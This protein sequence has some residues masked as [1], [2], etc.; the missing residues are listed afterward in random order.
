MKSRIAV[1]G[2]NK[3]VSELV[4]GT[5]WFNL[6]QKEASF[7][8]MDAFVLQGGTAIDTARIYGDGE[9]IIGEWMATRGNRNHIF[10][11]TKGGLSEKD[12][13]RLAVE[14]FKE[15][16]ARDITTSLNSLRTDH[17]DLYFLH[18]DEPTF[19]VEPIVDA[20]NAELA[21]GRIRS[22]GGSNWETRRIDEANEY[23]AKRGLTGFAAVSNNL[24]LAPPTAPFYPGLVSTDKAAMGWH[25]RTGIPLVSWACVA[26]GFF[27]GRFRPDV[28]DNRRM[29]EVYYTPD[30][31]ERLRRAEELGKKKGGF[32]AVQVALAWVLRQP[33]SV[34]PVIGCRT[35]EEMASSAD[36]LRLEMTNEEV[37]WLDL[38]TGPGR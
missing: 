28:R 20:L 3:P 31:F 21:N 29:V 25:A 8:L 9:A 15:K 11:I 30:N 24:S 7:R 6:P 33:L 19:P 4:L 38:D 26:R 16:V 17:I 12:G 5:A 13:S 34:F 36:A 18:R 10:V 27:T 22:F 35:P 1:R 23:A 2:V 14:C 32:S 37:R